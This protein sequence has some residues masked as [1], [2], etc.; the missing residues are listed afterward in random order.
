VYKPTIADTGEV[1]PEALVTIK[2][3]VPAVSPEIIV[4][5]PVPAV[6]VPP[7]DL[8]NIQVPV[9]GKPFNTTL[10]VGT[11][12]VGC[13]TVSIAGAVG[14]DGCV[15]ITALVEI[16]E[17][18][19][20]SLVTVKV[21]IPAA[22]PEIVVLVPDPME[23]VPSGVFVNVHAPVDGKPFN[24]TLPVAKVQVGCVI[25][26]TAG[27]DGVDGCALITT[28]AENGEGHPEALV[29]VKV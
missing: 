10:P 5:V 19:P 16:E 18:H 6:I 23:V 9:E 22:S 4:L 1:H 27:A 15:L 28:L 3:Y 24:T 12:N 20:D 8:V 25:V 29:T 7:G 21:Y 14:V 2:V 11:L 17:V 13:V 26:P